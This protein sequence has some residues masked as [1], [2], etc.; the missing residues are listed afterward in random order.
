MVNRTQHIMFWVLIAMLPGIAAMTFAWGW[1]VLWNLV[2]LT[3]AC[4]LIEMVC[5]RL[6]HHNAVRQRVADLSVVV[7][8]WLIAICLPPFVDWPVLLLGAAASV[9]LAKHA[10]GGLGRNLFN[11]AMVGYVVMLVSFPAA[12]AQ[13]PNPVDGLSG[14]T[15]LTEYQFRQGLTNDEFA[16]QFAPALA[17]QQ[18]ITWAFLGGGLL[19]V[20][21]GLLAWR[22]SVAIL[23]AVAVLA[24]LGYDQGSSNS[25]GSPWFHWSSGGLMAAAWFVATDPVT[26]PTARHHQIWFGVIIGALV[27]LI[28]TLGH[29]PDGI[30]FA[31]LLANCVTPL[32]NR[33]HLRRVQHG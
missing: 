17:D 31:V 4:V 29:Y 8:A 6:Q 16:T 28:R 23:A 11:P 15:L 7:T 19:L 1:G 21:R 18:L 25:L 30:A 2:I 27:Y 20:Y 9:G 14:A 5:L 24:M 3:F 33:L 32:F 22:I 26:H 10:Y 12:L 13:W